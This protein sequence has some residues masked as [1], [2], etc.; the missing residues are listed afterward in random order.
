MPSK[1]QTPAPQVAATLD[2]LQQEVEEL[3]A[4]LARGTDDDISKQARAASAPEPKRETMTDAIERVLRHEALS[5]V[6]VADRIGSPAG[7]V[8]AAMRAFKA[9]GRVYNLGSEERPRWIWVIGDSSTPEQLYATVELLV[10]IKPMPH[11]EIVAA[12]G[13]RPNRVNGVLVRLRDAERVYNL[14]TKNR[15]LW[16]LL[17]KGAKV[18]R[19]RSSAKTATKK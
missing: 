4:Q 1:T 14:G 7:P 12:T 15:A 17:P 16:F 13:A 10:S 2:R 5:I 6:E 3:R 18:S 8:A 19:V 11:E 9:S